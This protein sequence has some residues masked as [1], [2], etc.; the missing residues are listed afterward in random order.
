[1]P[2][3]PANRDRAPGWIRRP[4]I[5]RLCPIQSLLQQPK[6]AEARTAAD[7]ALALIQDFRCLGHAEVALRL[8]VSEACHAA[9]D[10]DRAKSELLETPR[11]I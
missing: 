11:Q 4:S 5:H 10:L 1:M 2:T 6:Y 9:G 3:N 8:A 7:D